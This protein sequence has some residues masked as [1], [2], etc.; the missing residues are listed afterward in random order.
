MLSNYFGYM[1]VIT[2][3]TVIAK[4]LISDSQLLSNENF[5][6][7]S[8]SFWVSEFEGILQSIYVNHLTLES[9]LKCLFFVVNQLS[10]AVKTPIIHDLLIKSYWERVSCVHS[11]YFHSTA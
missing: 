5:M 8:L 10:L 3:Y 2:Y 6:I 7:I 11:F 4:S 1:H 9:I